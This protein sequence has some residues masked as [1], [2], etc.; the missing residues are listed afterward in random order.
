M[1][2]ERILVRGVNWLGDA[3]MSTPALVR[4][5]ERFPRAHLSLLTPEKL[6]DLW[7]HHPAVDSVLS[8][9]PDESVWKLGRQLRAQRFDLAVVFPNSPRSALECRLARIPE[10][11][12]YAAR[13]RRWWLTRTVAPRPGAVPM[14]KRSVAEIRRLIRQPDEPRPAGARAEVP[15]DR[16]AHHVFHYLHLVATLGANPT[17]VVPVIQVTPQELQS[18]QAKFGLVTPRPAPGGW[19]GLNPGAEYGPAKRWPV[20]R[21]VAAARDIRKQ[22]GCGWLVFGGSGEVELATAIVHRLSSADAAGAGPE[23]DPARAVLNLAGRTTLRELCAGLKLCRAVLTNDTGPM[24]LAAA[25]GATVVVP[26]GSTSPELTG[27]GLPGDTHH[28]SL[29]AGVPC[30]PC[31]RRECPID[32][33][34]MHGIGVDLVVAAVLGAVRHPTRAD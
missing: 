21:F 34:C 20:E 9:A 27:P 26:F 11:V 17:P 13:W 8:F 23:R 12:G 33:R 30:A 10:R 15:P 3:V 14:R 5:R 4:L 6:A 18:F 2:P 29:R 1:N 22:T 19:L 31:F 24:H 32:F 25:V 7:W 16:E 28:A